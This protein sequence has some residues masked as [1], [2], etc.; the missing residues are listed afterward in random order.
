ML[1][2]K[3]GKFMYLKESD[4]MKKKLY[5]LLVCL[6]SSLN[7]FSQN[8][9]EKAYVVYNQ[10]EDLTY[11][12][13]A[14]FCQHPSIHENT[15]V[16]FETLNKISEPVKEICSMSAPDGAWN[17]FEKYK[18]LSF[19]IKCFTELLKEICGYVSSGLKEE[20]MFLIVDC[21]KG[22][23][24]TERVLGV[25]CDNAYFIEYQYQEFKML[26]VK[27]TLPAKFNAYSSGS[28]NLIEVQF[29]YNYQGLGGTYNVGA[30]K[31][32]M[33]QYRDNMKSDYYKLIRAT[34]KLIH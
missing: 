14:S 23:G 33:I 18:N 30:G 2:I 31:Y 34:S 25:E 6:F 26:F 3:E 27:N 1:M 29:S 21:L 10:L 11:D 17:L 28:N 19:Q 13:I 15:L 32:R 22:M 12:A 5:M 16:V 7:L 20:Q 4:L 8:S 9:E 24:W